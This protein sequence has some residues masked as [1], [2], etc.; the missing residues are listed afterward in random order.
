MK[1]TKRMLAGLCVALMLMQSVGE[2]TLTAVAAGRD[3]T[4]TAEEAFE[5]DGAGAA[6]FSNENTEGDA[7]GGD[8]GSAGIALYSASDSNLPSWDGEDKQV[9]DRVLVKKDGSIWVTNGETETGETIIVQLGSIDSYGVVTIRRSVGNIPSLIFQ[10]WEDIKELRFE[11]GAVIKDISMQSFSKC[12]YLKKVDFSNCQSLTQIGT[13]AFSECESLEEVKFHDNLQFIY[14]KAFEN[15]KALKSVTLVPG[16]IRVESYAFKGCASLE[17]VTLEA[18]NVRCSMGSGA[19]Q[20]IFNGCK[21]KTINFAL[22]NLSGDNSQDNVIVPA[23]LF[24]GA[25]FAEDADIVIPSNIQEIGEGAFGNTNLKK[26]TLEDTVSKPSLLST[27]GKKAFYKCASLES[28]TFPSTVQSLGESSFEGCLGLAE[29]VI[30]DSI[31]TLNTKAFYDCK[32]VATVKLSKATTTVGDYVFANCVALKEVDLPEGLTFTGKGEFKGCVGLNKVTIPSTMEIIGDETFMSCNELTQVRLPDSVTSLGK[33]AFES[34]SKLLT[35]HYSKSLREI[36]DRAFYDCISLSSNVFPET[37]EII[38]INAFNNCQ[39]FRNLTIPANVTEI[40]QTAFQNCHGIDVLTIES[41]KLTKCG[42]GIFNQCLLGTVHFPEGITAIPDNLFNQATFIANHTMTIPNTVTT[43]GAGAFG[44]TKAIP[45]NVPIIEFEKGTELTKIGDRAFTYCTALESF[46]IPETTEEIGANAFEGCI[47]ISSIVIPENVKKIGAS[48]FSDCEVLTDITYNAIHVTTKNLNIFKNCNVKKITIGGKVEAF[49]ANLF[50]DAKFST[51]DATGAEEMISIYIPASVETIG[52]YALPN[53]SNLQKVV[54]ADGSRLTT[55][56]QHAFQQCKNLVSLNLPDSVT[57]IGEYAFWN[58]P[59]LGSDSTEPFNVPASLVTLGS[60]AFQDCPFLTQVVI[61]SGVTKIEK[62]TFQNDTGLTSV[63]MAGGSLTEIGV[64]SFEGC[65]S[66]TEVSIPNGVTKIGATAFKGC[67]ALTKVLIPATVTSI[68][69]D[70]F[71][72]CSSKVQFMVVPGSYAEKWLD[73]K[74]IASSKLTPITYVLDGGLNNAKNPDGYEPG[75]TF[76]FEPATRKGYAFK[77]WYLDANF[78]TEIKG[79]EGCTENIT[80]YAKWEIDTYTITY[81]LDGGVNH[82]DN[83]VFYTINDKVDLKN[84]TK[85]GFTF[86]GWYSTDPNSPEFNSK[87]KVTSI[88]AGNSGDR[89]LYAKWNGGTTDAPVAS[90]ESGSEVKAGTKVFLTSDTPGARIY[91]TLDGTIPTEASSQYA[92]GIVIDRDLIVMAVAVKPNGVKSKVAFFIYSIRDENKFWG[93]ILPEDREQYGDSA[94]KVPNGIW[95]AGYEDVDYTGQKITFPNLRVYDGK[96]ILQ[97]KTDY[98]V[99]YANNTKAAEWNVGKKAPS[100]TITAKGNYKGKVVVNFTI[101]RLTIEGANFT[102]EDMAGSVTGK[103]QK[104]VPVLYYGKTKLKNRRDY[105]IKYF[106]VAE[107]GSETEVLGCDT[108]GK[109]R[110]ELTG[111]GNFRGVKSVKFELG[112]GTSVAKAKIIGLTACDYTGKEIT[113][114]FT[115]QVGGAVL[116]ETDYDVVYSNNVNAGTATVKIVGKGSYSGM[117]KATF[118]IKPIAT[119][120]KVSFSLNTTSVDYRGSAYEIGNGIEVTANYGGQ[121]LEK[122]RDYTCTYKNNKDAG[123]ATITFTG[124]G[125]YSGTTKKTFKIAGA[126]LSMYAISFLD[127]EGNIKEEASYPYEQGGVKPS[128]QLMFGGAPLVA[129]KDYTLSYKNN[130]AKGNA[131]LTLRGKKNFKGTITKSFTIVQQDVSELS[132]LAT[133]VV[134]KNSAGVVASSKPIVTDIN[135]KTLVEGT[136]YTVSYLYTDNTQL[137]DGTLKNANSAVNLTKDI[138]PA[139]TTITVKISGRGNYK[140]NKQNDYIRVCKRSIASAKVTVQ[141]QIYTGSEIQPDKDQ[142]TVKGLSK[143]DFEIVGYTNNIKK[144]TAKVTIRGVD[145][146]GG[147]KVVNFKIVQKPFILTLFERMF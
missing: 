42:V 45:V 71:S 133:D 53:I 27:I 30:P 8:D 103:S 82:K 146:Y 141:N 12:K 147:T 15:C 137:S 65:T 67:S 96:T 57:S 48:A 105:S 58:C 111:E 1:R 63:Q 112:G 100:I 4:P 19:A 80:I 36:K 34:C 83:P 142:M 13:Q 109:Y 31:N 143:D 9:N 11:S 91:Y 129:G 43:I 20:E 110:V 21:I 87:S 47:K 94:A 101:K 25:T 99:K 23:N 7:T 108:Q 124:M 95:V 28:I 92:G 139:E 61:P 73:D 29:L 145:N 54:F 115:V 18:A 70:A 106:K 51:N 81:E 55:I 66:L 26:V 104:P 68:A 121:P 89:T 97:E 117:K 90:I 114:N 120:N 75:D 39:S 17:S 14:S 126:D 49:P 84:P 62:Q 64:S 123:T 135:G 3:E 2:C 138:I 24:Y 46:T 93:D 79:V 59:K 130:T 136:D 144:G 134:Y 116:N 52:E 76:L 37:L 72:G 74:G 119:L 98:T 16:L 125:G 50:R 127:N 122:G 113:Q 38:G 35:I 86:E 5:G 77:G 88:S 10:G 41:N 60:S 102:A 118:K 140:G 33:S 128:I 40:G 69:D 32:N 132:V 44:G 78:Q 22:R 6:L 107:N 85:E 56:G 131:E